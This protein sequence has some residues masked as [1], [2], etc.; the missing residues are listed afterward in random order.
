[1][2]NIVFLQQLAE[3]WLGVMYISSMLKSH[4]HQCKVYVEPLEKDDLAATALS[5]PPDAV[6]FSCL[7]SDF[8]W[9][10][11]KA[12]AVKRHSSALTVFGGT[13]ITLNPDEAI[14]NPAVDIICQGEG[15]YPM[16]ELAEAIDRHQ[17]PSQISG[18][19]VKKNGFIV[20]NEMRNLIQDLDSLPYP[21]RELYAKYPFFRKRGKRPLHLSRGCPY[22][23][24][25][26]HNASKRALFKGKGNYVRW[27]SKEGVLAE[28]REIREKSFITVLHVI[29]DAFGI[30]GEWLKDFLARLSDSEGKRLAIQANL[31]ADMVTEDMCQAFRDYGA[32]LLRLRIAVECGDENYRRDVLRKNVLNADLFRAASLFHKHDI[33]FTTYNMAGL[34]AETLEQALETLRLNVKLRPSMAIC[35][36]YQPYP[37]TALCDYALQQGVLTREM[38]DKMGTPEYQ[39]FYHSA[40]VLNQS[41]IKK[42]ENLQ[43]VFGL[44]ARH[45][46]LLPL[47]E[48]IVSNEALSPLLTW[49]YRGYVRERLLQR[50]LRDKY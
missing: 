18:L 31:R 47:A 29:D 8:H 30:N 45:P 14:S 22:D 44:V 43:K 36:V 32:H 11:A 13:H 34:P 15:E 24:S 28:I 4:G 10:L 20:K 3:E 46:F 41:G 50:R 21:D 40:S 1:M 33:D 12:R 48:P 25:Y 23:C 27:R 7:T 19:W 6:A 26:C 39:G 35:F 42:I 17:D 5:D 2:A 38:L 37:G 49:F 16:L 9:A